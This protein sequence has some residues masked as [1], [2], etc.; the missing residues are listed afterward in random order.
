MRAPCRPRPAH[1]A[2]LG[3]TAHTTA[4]GAAWGRG[5]RQANLV[6]RARQALQQHCAPRARLGHTAAAAAQVAAHR[7]HLGSTA[8]QLAPRP[9]LVGAARLVGLGRKT[10]PVQ[11][12]H[13]A[14]RVRLGNTRALAAWIAAAR[15]RQGRCLRLPVAP[16]AAAALRAPSI[17][18]G[19][20]GNARNAPQA[21]T[22]TAA[23]RL[24][25]TAGDGEGTAS[26]P[27]RH[28][29]ARSAPPASS[30]CG[31]RWMR[32]QLRA[33]RARL[34]HTAAATAQV[35]AH[36]ARLGRTAEQ[37]A[38]RSALVEAARLAGLGRKTKPVQQRHCAPRVRL[39]NTRVLAAWITASRARQGRRLR[40]PVAP[41]AA[42]AL[43]APSIIAVGNARNAPQA[44]TATATL[45]RTAGDGE[46]TAPA[47]PPPR[48][49][50]A[51]GAPPASSGSGGRWM[52]LQL[53]AKRA[54]W[55]S[56]S[57]SWGSLCVAHAFRA[58]RPRKCR[59]R[60][61][62]SR[63]QGCT[64]ERQR[65]FRGDCS[66]HR[67]PPKMARSER[68]ARRGA[69]T[70]LHQHRALLA[71]PA[72]VRASRWILAAPRTSAA[73]VL[74]G[75]QLSVRTP[76]NCRSMAQTGWCAAL[77]SFAA[78]PAPTRCVLVLLATS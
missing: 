12:R 44:S 50:R 64:Q 40:L 39:G 37:L 29:R 21:S 4:T 60:A 24:P 33:P 73:S 11:Q 53:R 74:M 66:L 35:A 46:G 76:C 45:S 27:P 42:A 56:S 51:R 69:S 36:R 47:P 58:A 8:E 30:G 19:A 57:Q 43:R 59:V 61:R 54:R 17:T 13:C 55:A 7:A 67:T 72:L 49:A 26:A 41:P 18:L 25:R 14:P 28:A 77:I 71:A 20:V 5:A 63:P 6:H 78:T 32:L 22:A 15:A 38:P 2:P 10:K 52:R 48:H 9:A 23:L 70:V 34:G 1:P 3:S 16:P 68:T 65:L 62:A 75:G 31:G